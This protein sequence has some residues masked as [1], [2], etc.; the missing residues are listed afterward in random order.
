[1]ELLY[2][3]LTQYWEEGMMLRKNKWFRIVVIIIVIVAAGSIFL[4]STLSEN[5]E[6]LTKEPIRDV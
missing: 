6:E 2:G 5:L 3:K 4:Y 1:M